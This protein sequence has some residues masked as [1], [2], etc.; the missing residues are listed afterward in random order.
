MKLPRPHPRYHTP[1]EYNRRWLVNVLAHC[2]EDENG[3]IL[4]DGFIGHNGYGQSSFR[5]KGCRL[6]RKVYEIT[7]GPI[8]A[9]HDVCHSCD[10][11]RCIN[12]KHLWTGTRKDN[13]VD[14]LKKGRHHHDQVTHCPYGHE[15]AIHGRFIDTGKGTGKGRQCSACSRARQRIR[16][17]WPPDLARSMPPGRPGLKLQQRLG[18]GEGDSR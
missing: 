8:P 12:P 2:H 9:G 6:H 1:E 4:W 11:R 15:F 14:C 17:G 3:C 7:K 18:L 5:G 13:L 16:A 10:V